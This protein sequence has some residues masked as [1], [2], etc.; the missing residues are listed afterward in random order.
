MS[1]NTTPDSSPPRSLRARIADLDIEMV[2]TKLRVKARQEKLMALGLLP[3]PEV[4][5]ECGATKRLTDSV[6]SGIRNGNVPS[7]RGW[8][9]KYSKWLRILGNGS[10][11]WNRGFH[12]C[13]H[14]YAYP[15][16]TH[17]KEIIAEPSTEKKTRFL[18]GE[19][20]RLV[21]PTNINS[22]NHSC[23][24]QVR[25]RSLWRSGSGQI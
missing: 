23:V 16:Q 2:S 5:S 8:F 24:I 12:C 15:P 25:G 1:D 6:V 9:A 4:C 13:I 7:K 14:M 11:R 21:F 18:K 3:I 17:N 20:P 19:K 10:W 22:N